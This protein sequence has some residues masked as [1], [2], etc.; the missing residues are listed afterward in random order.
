MNASTE[1]LLLE[2]FAEDVVKRIVRLVNL[3]EYKRF[4]AAPV[5]RVTSKAFGAGRKIPLVHKF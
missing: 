3:N 5:L 4:Q 1:D 2:G